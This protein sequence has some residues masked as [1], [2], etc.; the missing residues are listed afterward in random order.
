[1]IPDIRSSPTRHPIR[2]IRTLVRITTS[3]T[4]C[5]L[6]A[7]S[8]SFAVELF[9][10][11]PPST[12]QKLTQCGFDSAIRLC[13]I[14]AGESP[15]CVTNFSGRRVSSDD[16]GR[17]TRQLLVG[18]GGNL[19]TIRQITSCGRKNKMLL[20]PFHI[21]APEITHRDI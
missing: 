5:T 13:D 14:R 17:A 12:S 3:S 10:F 4:D 9:P 7:I 1:M 19:M 6:S 8:F 15:D 2:T 16:P 21:Q 20:I 11:A 18:I